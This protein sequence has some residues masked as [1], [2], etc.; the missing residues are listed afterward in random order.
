MQML[1]L[2]AMGMMAA[3]RPKPPPT[4][5]PTPVAPARDNERQ[6]RAA[7]AQLEQ[8]SAQQG[9]SST[10]MTGNAGS[11]APAFSNTVLGQ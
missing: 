11:P 4:P 1:P 6:R 10:N 8:R 9:R 7:N 3:N 5:Q 2:L